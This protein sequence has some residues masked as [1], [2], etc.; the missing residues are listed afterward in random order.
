MSIPKFRII[1]KPDGRFFVDV[2]G[3]LPTGEFRNRSHPKVR[4]RKQAEDYANGV[5]EAA[6]RGEVEKRQPTITVEEY[7][8]RWLAARVAR[9]LSSAVTNKHELARLMAYLGNKRITRLSRDDI[10]DAMRRLEAE[11]ES[12]RGGGKLAPRSIRHS[13]TTFRTML[14]DAVA[15]G[16]ISINPANLKARRDEIPTI[17][18]KNP[19]WRR[20]AVYTAAEIETLTRDA[21]VSATERTAYALECMAGLRYGEASALRWSDWDP[22]LD[23]L[24]RLVIHQAYD[25]NNRRVK[26]TK[27]ENTRWVPVVPA[28]ATMLED[29]WAAGWR[30]AYGRPPKPTDLVMPFREGKT[31]RHRTKNDGHD[32]HV[33]TLSALGFSHRRQHDLRRTFVTMCRA[34]GAQLDLLKWISHG[35]PKGVVIDDYTSPPWD[36]LCRQVQCFQVAFMAQLG[37]AEIA[38]SKSA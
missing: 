28:L 29:W 1:Q 27:T 37:H 34:G 12:K 7:A 5:W 19:H 17:K 20:F 33:R 8:E 3:M 22:D 6:L 25:S 32:R 26:E 4:T 31:L 16:L 24:G 38:Q 11:G 10:L 21:R 18:D 36:S 15:D 13:Y 30:K 14:E 2:R 35:P 9:A 23:P